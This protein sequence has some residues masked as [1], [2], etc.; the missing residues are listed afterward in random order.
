MTTA[1]AAKPTF[2][3]PGDVADWHR[4]CPPGPLDFLRNLRVSE[5]LSRIEYAAADA[6]ARMQD[7][8]ERAADLE[9]QAR[10]YLEEHQDGEQAALLPGA[11]LREKFLTARRNIAELARRLSVIDATLSETDA[12]ARA[13]DADAAA[14]AVA[15]PGTLDAQPA[16]PAAGL[17][18]LRAQR[19]RVAA[20][21]ALARDGANAVAQLLVAHA[22]IRQAD[23]LRRATERAAVE[24]HEALEAM[25][26]ATVRLARA[27][28]GPVP[29]D[30]LERAARA[31]GASSPRAA[32]DP[33]LE[34]DVIAARRALQQP[35][36]GVA[37][38]HPE[39]LAAAV[40]T[41]T[42]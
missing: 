37:A 14:R 36:A 16:T 13:Q 26:G 9:R 25:S 34:A 1:A 4:A 8:I 22:R 12:A 41:A 2:L 5:F 7:S 15:D 31:A 40:S 42:R 38:N 6:R 19:A 24:L 35:I 11:T 23:A 29:L 18:E 27:A 39:A 30:G 17:D 28:L 10:A 3:Y 33:G 32:S 21:H 20:A